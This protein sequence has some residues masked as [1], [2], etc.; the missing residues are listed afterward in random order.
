MKLKIQPHKVLGVLLILLSLGA[1]IH[2]RVS[3][4]AKKNEIQIGS[5]KFIVE[6]TRIVTIPW[7]LSAV[8]ALAGAVLFFSNPPKR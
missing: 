2:P 3:M 6:T 1:F 5:E 7:Y 8:V 4:P